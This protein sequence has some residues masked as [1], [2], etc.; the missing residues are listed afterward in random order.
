L[1]HVRS[2]FLTKPLTLYGLSYLGMLPISL[3]WPLISEYYAGSAGY[4]LV[5]VAVIC[6]FLYLAHALIIAYAFELNRKRA[7]SLQEAARRVAAVIWPLV[8]MA[9]LVWLVC[10][11]AHSY[12]PPPIP[13][14]VLTVFCAVAVPAC[15]MERLGALASL[16]RS[17]E[18]TQGCRLKVLLVIGTVYAVNYLVIYRLLLIVWDRGWMGGLSIAMLNN[19]LYAASS[20]FIYLVYAALYYELRTIKDFRKD[21]RPDYKA[22]V[23]D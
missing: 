1:G 21:F 7:G 6:L 10:Q 19:A 15:L 17:F 8:M 16:K 9:L 11:G 14:I 12:L 2:T 13:E 18:L 23:F 4:A 3:I 5:L 22:E 20:L